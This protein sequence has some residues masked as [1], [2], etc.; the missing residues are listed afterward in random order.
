AVAFRRQGVMNHAPT[1]SPG[2][3]SD[4]PL[5]A[6]RRRL[7]PSSPP[8]SVLAPPTSGRPVGRPAT[9]RGPRAARAIPRRTRR[10]PGGIARRPAPP[11]AR[12]VGPPTR[13]PPPRRG[14][15]APLVLEPTPAVAQVVAPD[16]RGDR[17]ARGGGP[18]LTVA[19]PLLP[20]RGGLP[21]RG[22]R[23]RR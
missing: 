3:A 16:L 7:A 6:A 20:I 9:G 5:P 13:R 10:R 12:L 17:T 15:V 1:G 11:G 22:R 18:A 14:A 8:R 19:G 4:L 21:R 23:P 2:I